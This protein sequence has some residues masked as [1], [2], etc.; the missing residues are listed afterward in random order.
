[1]ASNKYVLEFDAETH[2]LM[3]K[4]DAMALKLRGLNKELQFMGNSQGMLKLTKEQAIFDKG[5][6]KSVSSIAALKMRLKEL[7][8][9]K[10]EYLRTGATRVSNKAG[11]G[12][13]VSELAGRGRGPKYTPIGAGAGAKR[14]VE[15]INRAID[16][17]NAKLVKAR[18]NFQSLNSDQLNM[19][20]GFAQGIPGYDK[21]LRDAHERENVEARTQRMLSQ[22]PP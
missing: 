19:A 20:Q 1:M 14:G 9:A 3:A 10:E 21:L 7:T 5:L 12:N 18:S 17:T 16:A 13:L 8:R 6:R 4:V 2:A 15:E 22:K 11:A